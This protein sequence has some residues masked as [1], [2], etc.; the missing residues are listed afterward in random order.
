MNYK[1]IMKSSLVAPLIIVAG[2]LFGAANIA[3]AQGDSE[4]NQQLAQVRA[5][6]AKYH[7]LNAAIEDGYTLGAPGGCFEF[8]EGA[9]GIT[10]VNVPRFISPEVDPSEPEILNYIPVGDGSIRLITVVYTNRALFRDTRPPETPGYRPGLFPWQQPVIPPYLEEVSGSFSLFGQQA[11]LDFSGRWLYLLPVW[12]WSP[13]PSGM[14]AHLNPRL[15][16]M[17]NN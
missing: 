5:T 2:I 7:D 3:K 10:Y 14:F 4:L 15:N 1:K 17:A 8:A 12:V 9:R 16:C 11:A 13:N 6:T